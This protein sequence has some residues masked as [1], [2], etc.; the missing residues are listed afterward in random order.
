ME[1]DFN[2]QILLSST[3]K[4]GTIY[5]RCDDFNAMKYMLYKAANIA[6]RPDIFLL[7][8]ICYVTCYAQKLNTSVVGSEL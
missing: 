2:K 1:Y 8:R 3:T 4:G 5:F 7:D 6:L